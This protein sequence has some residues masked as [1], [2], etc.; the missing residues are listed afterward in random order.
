[1]TAHLG[2]DGISILVLDVAEGHLCALMLVEL[3]VWV[4]GVGDLV[5]GGYIIGLDQKTLLS[6]T[7]SMSILTLA[8]DNEPCDAHCGVCGHL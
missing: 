6:Q 4:I 7:R 1:M 3:E 8:L 2:H 5:Q